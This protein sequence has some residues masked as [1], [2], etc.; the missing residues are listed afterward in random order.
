MIVKYIQPYKR[1]FMDFTY[2]KLYNAEFSENSKDFIYIIDD[3]GTR[4][5]V[6]IKDFEIIDIYKTI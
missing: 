5:I 1:P 2:N 6:P 4:M 3:T